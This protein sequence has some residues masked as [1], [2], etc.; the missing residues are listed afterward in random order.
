MS[1]YSIR[2]VSGNEKAEPKNEPQA[3]DIA[4]CQALA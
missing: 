2:P 1:L 4:F 3:D